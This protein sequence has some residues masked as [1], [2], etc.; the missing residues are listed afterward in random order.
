MYALRVF[1]LCARFARADGCMENIYLARIFWKKY[2]EKS[3]Y[4]EF[5]ENPYHQTFSKKIMP[6]KLDISPEEKAERRREQVRAAKARQTTRDY[7]SL[8]MIR[9]EVYHDTKPAAVDP[10]VEEVVDKK[11]RKIYI[12]QQ[13][14]GKVKQAIKKSFDMKGVLAEL[15]RLHINHE[16]GSD[17]TYKNIVNNVIW[18]SK[19]LHCTDDFLSCL[20]KPK[21]FFAAMY[22]G[23]KKND[24]EYALGT[25]KKRVD[26]ALVLISKVIDPI[27]QQR[28]YVS[29]KIKAAY[30][31]EDAILRIKVDQARAHRNATAVLLRWVDAFRIVAARYG[32]D[33]PEYLIFK[34]YKAVPVRDDLELQIVSFVRDTK[35]NARDESNKNNHINFLV[36]PSKGRCSVV[37]NHYKTQERHGFNHR[38][39]LDSELS[40][41]VRVFV[42]KNNLSVGDF[43]FGNHSQT[44]FVSKIGKDISGDM[45]PSVT[46]PVTITALRRMSASEALLNTPEQMH[47]FAKKMLHSVSSQVHYIGQSSV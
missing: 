15:E 19:S 3:V 1:I 30:A 2:I 44:N 36:I 9:R 43:L 31:D 29:D 7:E 41:L 23:R 25:Y 45:P 10:I 27:G 20:K 38:Y 8:N 46:V 42:K 12:V 21:E 16:L 28:Q 34:L 13:G 39:E 18:M 14:P 33:S 6:A 4:R 35:A 5:I 32:T 17:V 22:E 24:D 37:I 40:K 26:V 47:A 11:K